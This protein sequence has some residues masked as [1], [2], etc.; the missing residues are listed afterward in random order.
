MEHSTDGIA[1]TAIGR[2]NSRP[3][4]YQF[5]GELA[6]VS[7]ERLYYRLKMVDKNGTVRYSHIII[8][9]K[10]PAGA[11]VIYPNPAVRGRLLQISTPGNDAPQMVEVWNVSGQ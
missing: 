9:S 6:G 7:G 11:V 1:F 10:R 4:T 3:H 8:R 2:V 5:T